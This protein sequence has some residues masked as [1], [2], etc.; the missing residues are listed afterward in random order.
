MTTQLIILKSDAMIINWILLLSPYQ[1]MLILTIPYIILQPYPHQTKFSSFVNSIKKIFAFFNKV[2]PQLYA[3]TLISEL[4]YSWKLSSSMTIDQECV[5][6]FLKYEFWLF[7]LIP[8]QPNRN[9]DSWRWNQIWT[10]KLSC[11]T[12]SEKNY[13][14][15]LQHKFRWI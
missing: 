14:E 4:L 7:L 10:P 5:F 9:S 3:S 12:N 1:V 6:L 2:Y 13:E 15:A 8:F 11:S